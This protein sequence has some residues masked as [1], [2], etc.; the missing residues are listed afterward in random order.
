MIS[1]FMCNILTLSKR[2]THNKGTYH[3][4]SKLYQ[5]Q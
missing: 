2:N 3:G 4:K 5:N 1:S